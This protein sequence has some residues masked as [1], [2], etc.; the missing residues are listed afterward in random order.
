M[1][2]MCFGDW[3]RQRRRILGLTQREYAW[4]CR[5]DFT[6]LSK[7]E[8]NRLLPADSVVGYIIGAVQDTLSYDEREIMEREAFEAL[9]VTKRLGLN[10]L[11]LLA[12]V[13]SEYVDDDLPHWQQKLERWNTMGQ[14]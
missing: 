8:N 7:I 12:P 3:L 5:I 1:N 2:E 11:Q 4:R 10:E 13:S 6:I 14:S 9:E